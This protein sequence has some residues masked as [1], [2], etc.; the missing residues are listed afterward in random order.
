MLA[1]RMAGWYPAGVTREQE[2]EA[3]DTFI[4]AHGVTCCPAKNVLATTSYLPM[5]IAAQ[6]LAELRV[7]RSD[8]YTWLAVAAR[9]FM[10][11]MSRH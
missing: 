7:R 4:A 1:F 2:L 10:A 5:V 3:I 8:A 6:R 11:E 9:V